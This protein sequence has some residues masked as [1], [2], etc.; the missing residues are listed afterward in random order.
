MKFN[1]KEIKR[2]VYWILYYLFARHL[3]SNYAPYAFGA[4]ELR[5]FLCKSL[6]QRFGK[7]VDIGPKVEFFNVRNSEIGD[8]SGIGAYSSIGTVKIGNY[9]MMGTHCLILSQNHHFD[10]LTIPM[11]QQGFQED[12]PVIIEDDVWI[13]SRVIILPGVR[14]GHGSIIG[15]GAVVTKS[16]EPYTIVGGNPAKVIGHRNGVRGKD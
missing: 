13:G 1:L 14:I 15:A 16:V 11:C 4:K 8:N 10:D 6:F 3:P 9:V 7:N 5:A 2:S 12:R